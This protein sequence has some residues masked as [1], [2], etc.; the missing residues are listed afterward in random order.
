MKRTCPITDADH[1]RLFERAYQ[2]SQPGDRADEAMAAIL[3][4]ALDA[5]EREDAHE[6]EVR[7]V[8]MEALD[9]MR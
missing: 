1:R 7:R 2:A 5:L 9:A 6:A 3:G 8:A 4:R